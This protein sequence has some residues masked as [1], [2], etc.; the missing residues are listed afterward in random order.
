M[1]N[2]RRPLV[3]G[4]LASFVLAPQIVRWARPEPSPRPWPTRQPTPP[5]SLPTAGGGTWSLADA[6]GQVLVL[7]FWASWC[8]PCRAEMPSLER[9]AARQQAKGLRV[10]AVNF[11]ETDDEVQRFVQQTGLDLSILLDRDGAVA[12]AWGVSVFPT[13]VVV[14]RRGRAAFTVVGEADWSGAAAQ[15]WLQPLLDAN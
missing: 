9:L 15:G 4:L 2:G 6:G 7:N 5:L 8:A 12:Q 10:V 13:T 3:L 14:D 11:R 1:L